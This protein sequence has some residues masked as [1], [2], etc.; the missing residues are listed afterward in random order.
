[1]NKDL[2]HRVAAI[3]NRLDFL[4]G[5]VL[6]LCKLEDVFLS[7]DKL[8]TAVLHNK[9]ERDQNCSRCGS[10]SKRFCCAHRK[11]FPDVSGVQPSV[12][13]DR[14]CSSL[15]IIQVALEHV[16]SFDADLQQHRGHIK[17]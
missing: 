11:P 14:L 3:I 1:M 8:Q 7:V 12:R 9:E 13:I 2:G 17:T 5:D 6:S 4:R 16:W 15:R 10:E